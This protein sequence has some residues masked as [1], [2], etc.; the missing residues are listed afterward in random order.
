[1]DFAI[2]HLEK[3]TFKFDGLLDNRLGTTFFLGFFINWRLCDGRG[4]V[5]SDETDLLERGQKL[6][7][8]TT[9][10]HMKHKCDE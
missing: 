5:N 3:T 10:D 1:M 6:M 7:L 9:N 4:S 2:G 8:I